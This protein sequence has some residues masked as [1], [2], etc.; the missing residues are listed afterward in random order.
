VVRSVC[1]SESYLRQALSPSFQRFTRHWKLYLSQKD[2]RRKPEEKWR[3]NVVVPYAYSGVR[4][5]VAAVSDIFNSAEPLIEPDAVAVEHEADAKSITRILDYQLRMDHWALKFDKGLTDAGVQGTWMPK[6]VHAK[7]S[8]RVYIVANEFD[9]EE[10]KKRVAEAEMVTNLPAP[11]DAQDFEVWRNMVNQANRGVKVPEFPR[12]GWHEIIEYSGPVVCHDPIFQYRYDPFVDDIQSQEVIIHRVVKTK[13]WLMANTGS[14][15]NKMYDEAQVKAA[16]ETGGDNDRFS[17][18]QHEVSAM[19]GLDSPTKD[20]RYQQAVELWEVWRKDSQH[21]YLTILNRK[22]IISKPDR[23]K[24]HSNPYW[25]GR[26]PFF[27]IHNVPV[28][29]YAHGIS[30]IAPNEP[31]YHE[32]NTMRDLRLDAVTLRVLPV[33][34]RMVGCNIPELSRLLQPGMVI[35]V[36]RPEA[37]RPLFEGSMEGVMS[38]FREIDYIKQDIDETNSTPSSLRGGAATV[39]R[40]SATES[41]DRVNRALGRQKQRVLTM[42]DGLKPYVDMSLF[43]WM[44]FHSSGERVRVGGKDPFVTLRKTMF[45]EALG[46]DYRFRGA[47]KALN[48]DMAAQKLENFAKLFM[49]YMVPKEIRAL[50]S[51]TYDA[52][53]QKGVEEVVSEAGTQ[54]LT[55]QY[56]MQQAAQ[57]AQMGAPAPAPGGAPAGDPAAAAAGGAPGAGGPTELQGA[58]AQ[59]MI[60]AMGGAGT[61]QA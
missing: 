56:E 18:W 39:G 32:M 50:M 12:S 19:M 28:A 61:S 43:L 47:S 52:I 4:T 5:M 2:D 1:D 30:E 15:P 60:S 14:G 9:L 16:L 13:Q 33:F 36:D 55:Q 48:R 11:D 27:P 23:M 38:A 22:A 49:Q 58:D 3:A 6:L 25:H 24:C 31:L 37:I 51:R 8:Q 7:K 17:E 53:G 10:W 54:S 44:Q 20:P 26:Y 21:P 34:M 46:M 41:T 35:P 40:V 45:Q 29:G 57:M 42:E 59:A